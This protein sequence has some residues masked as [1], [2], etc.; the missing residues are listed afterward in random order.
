MMILGDKGVEYAIGTTETV[1]SNTMMASW[2]GVAYAVKL[3][4]KAGRKKA[5]PTLRPCHVFF[6][7][8]SLS[9]GIPGF[10]L[11]LENENCPITLFMCCE[12]NTR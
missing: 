1:E 11:R 5:T 12:K 9:C 3:Y 6:Y 7:L 10:P 8:V 4:N 2:E